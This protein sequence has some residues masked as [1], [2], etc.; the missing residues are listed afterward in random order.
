[1]T[2]DPGIAAERLFGGTATP[3]ASAT[4][5]APAPAAP[6]PAAAPAQ[7]SDAANMARLEKLF[8]QPKPEGDATAKPAEAKTAEGDKA[9]TVPATFDPALF[10]RMHRHAAPR[11]PARLTARCTST[12]GRA[13]V[14]RG[15][16]R[17][18]LGRVRP[19]PRHRAAETSGVAVGSRSRPGLMTRRRNPKLLKVITYMACD[20]S[21]RLSQGRLD[22]CASLSVALRPF[23]NLWCRMR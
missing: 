10:G 18:W 13:G 6:A 21:Q 1:M 20:W 22:S 19:S 23:I 9:D 15:K 5:A 8:G 16:R 7:D 3:P 2:I 12:T 17:R 4:P 14:S 11:S